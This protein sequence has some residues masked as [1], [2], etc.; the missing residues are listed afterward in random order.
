LGKKNTDTLI[1]SKSA[2][3]ACF[4]DL[5]KSMFFLAKST[6]V[7]R[8]SASAAHAPQSGKF[9]LQKY[10]E[11]IIWRFYHDFWPFLAQF[12]SWGSFVSY[13]A[14]IATRTPNTRYPPSL[15]RKTPCHR[16]R[17]A[18]AHAC[19]LRV[20]ARGARGA[21]AVGVGDRA[22]KLARRTWNAAIDVEGTGRGHARASRTRRGRHRRRPT[23]MGHMGGPHHQRVRTK[24]DETKNVE[25]DGHTGG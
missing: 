12:F 10:C 13:A 16:T 1:I 9:F 20:R 23:V 2:L 21:G 5:T 14:V 6:W 17:G 18:S 19:I 24:R 8:A 3:K 25:L 15:R 11:L 22:R 4:A 7:G